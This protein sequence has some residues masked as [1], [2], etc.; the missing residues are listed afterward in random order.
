MAFGTPG[1]YGSN[2]WRG[3]PSTSRS[4]RTT[5]GS[6]RI[7]SKTGGTG[8]PAGRGRPITDIPIVMRHLREATAEIP[9][10][11]V[12]RIAE[13][14][15]FAVQLQGAPYKL[16]GNAGGRY[17]L[18]ATTEKASTGRAGEKSRWVKGIPRGFWRIVEEGSNKHLIAG[19]HRKGSGNRFTS[20]GALSSFLGDGDGTFRDTAFNMGTPVNYMGHSKGSNEGWAQYVVHPGHGPIGRPW[21]RSEA[22]APVIQKEITE[23]YAKTQLVRA[24]FR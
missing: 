11:T 15:K 14:V 5:A 20:K 24:F 16:R 4:V 19:R 17:A 1:G 8:F 13:A 3:A 10:A 2:P 18:G 12:P 9:E 6:H 21:K 23:N 7:D 22:L